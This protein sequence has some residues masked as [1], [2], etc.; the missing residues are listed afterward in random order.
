MNYIK[1]FVQN[2]VIYYKF[3]RKCGLL[4]AS[5]LWETNAN[6]CM[7]LGIDK[8]NQKESET[9]TNYINKEINL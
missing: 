8:A 7:L 1:F 9:A 5:L 4:E 6:L 2:R 3:Y